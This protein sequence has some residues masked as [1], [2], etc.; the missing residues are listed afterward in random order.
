MSGIACPPRST[1]KPRLTKTYDQS[2]VNSIATLE[3]SWDAVAASQRFW[4]HAVVVKLVD[5]LS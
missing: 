2:R 1:L 4:F 5:T 3:A